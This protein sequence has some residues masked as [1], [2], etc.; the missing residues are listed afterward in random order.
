MKKRIISLVL[1]VVLAMSL[2][3]GCGSKE[4][5]GENGKVKNVKIG[6]ILYNYTDIQGKEIKNYCDNYLAKEFPVSFEYQT[7]SSGDNEAHLQAVDSLI[8]TGCDAIMSGYDTVVGESMEKCDSAKVYYGILFGEAKDEADKD[9]KYNEYGNWGTR[10]QSNLY[11]SDY[12]LGGIY[13]FGADHGEALGEKY[14]QAVVDAGMKNVGAISFPSYAFSDAV[15]ICQGFSKV[16]EANGVNICPNED[17]NSLPE[18]AGFT[19]VGDDTKAYI[20]K[21]PEMDGLFGLSSGMDMVLPAVNEV[22]RLWSESNSGDGTM[23]MAALGY[24]ESS[25][26]YLENGTLLIGGTNNYVESVAYLFT[27]MFDAVNGNNMKTDDASGFEY[28]ASISYPTFSNAEELKDFQTYVLTTT[29][30]DFS[31]CSVTADEMK[32]VM[33]A[34]DG[35]GSWTELNELVSRDFDVVKAAR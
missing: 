9:G 28:N 23:K 16:L 35:S 11:Y 5:S 26:K 17:T 24:N 27:M 3:V 2:I 31:T 8:S 10:D 21:Y 13:Q 34:Y 19:T 14:G 7:A 4:N 22:G 1:I 18:E 15:T 33:K 25:E 29:A 32:T 20:A 12:F 30:D 6:V